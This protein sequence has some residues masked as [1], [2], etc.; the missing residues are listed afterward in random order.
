MGRKSAI[1]RLD[2]RIREAVDGAIRE[3][4][5]TIED[6]VGLIREMGGQASASSVGRYKQNAEAQMAR[7]REAQ[8]IAR[9]WVGK[10]QADPEGDVGR[11]LAEML[12]TT[13]FQTL[14]GMEAGAPQDV[15]FLAKALK[16]LASADKL[17]AERILKV[18]REM[19]Q[20]AAEKAATVAK[21]KGLTRETVE[22]LRR[23][24]LGLA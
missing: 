19:A 6:I 14:G 3:G 9:V 11:L 24:L 17:T 1:T 18:R 12:R 10:L 8:E 21:A 4:R 23:E 15:M 20:E 22:E 16:D 2:P 13:A 5:A 7:Y